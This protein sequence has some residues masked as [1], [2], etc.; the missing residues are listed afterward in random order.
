MKGYRFLSNNKNKKVM[1]KLGS[2]EFFSVKNIGSRLEINKKLLGGYNI[3]LKFV[4]NDNPHTNY[5]RYAHW[6]LHYWF[7]ITLQF[8]GGHT[9]FDYQIRGSQNITEVPLE[10]YEPL[11]QSMVTS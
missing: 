3:L 11:F 1:E 7:M 10:I 9:I 6:G 4:F 8:R 2:T 5:Q